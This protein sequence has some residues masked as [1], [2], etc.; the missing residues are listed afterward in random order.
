MTLKSIKARLLIAA[1]IAVVCFGLVLGYC[2]RSMFRNGVNR[3]NFNRVQV[4][5]TQAEVEAIMC[6]PGESLGWIGTEDIAA[7]E[8]HSLLLR[9]PPRRGECWQ[10]GTHQLSVW[11][12]AQ[13]EVVCK[14]YSRL[15]ETGRLERF[16]DW[17]GL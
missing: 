5:M 11:Y 15:P 2:L 7:D 8:R 9:S 6:R 3:A 16:L 1:L 4:G 14:Y 13:G 17:A 12:D 10:S